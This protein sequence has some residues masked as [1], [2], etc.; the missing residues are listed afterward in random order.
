MVLKTI[1]KENLN[2]RTPPPP[3]PSPFPGFVLKTNDLFQLLKLNGE[4]VL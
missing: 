3:A 1:G 4:T 2:P